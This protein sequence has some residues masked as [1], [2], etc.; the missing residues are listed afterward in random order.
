MYKNTVAPM[1]TIL[2][3]SKVDTGISDTDM[4][5]TESNNCR[6]ISGND[7]DANGVLVIICVR[8]GF[9]CKDR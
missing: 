6:G 8:A 7:R 1:I 5:T 4:K 9:S 2:G 3:C